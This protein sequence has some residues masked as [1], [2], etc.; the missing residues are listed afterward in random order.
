MDLVAAGEFREDLYYRLNVFPVLVPPLRAR[1]DDIAGLARHFIA[2]FAASEGKA[3][4]GADEETMALLRNFDWPGNV[5]QLENMIYRAVVL[6]DDAVLTL[7]DFPQMTQSLGRQNHAEPGSEAELDGAAALPD[8]A[9][10]LARPGAA[11]GL[12]AFGNGGDIKTL[13]EVEGEVIRL[14]LEHY[15]GQMSEAARR[16]GIGRSTLYRKV[17]EHGLEADYE[18][19]AAAEPAPAEV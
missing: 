5:R 17:R 3:V 16:L 2:A 12:A 4:Q 7:T 14:A 8:G 13:S 15:Q 6:A 18:N 10:P 11:I 1:R 19:Q 9:S